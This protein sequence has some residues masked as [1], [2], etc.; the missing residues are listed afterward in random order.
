[1]VGSHG[2]TVVRLLRPGLHSGTVPK[3][4]ARLRHAWGPAAHKQ[5][6]ALHHVEASLRHFVE[7]DLLA[8]LAGSKRWGGMALEAAIHLGT[9]RIRCELR[10][11]SLE[12]DKVCLDFEEHADRLLARLPPERGWLPRLSPVQ[13]AAFYDALVGFCKLA[14]AELKSAEMPIAWSDWVLTWE[15]DQESDKQAALSPGRDER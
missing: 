1:V 6:E 15:R 13:S 7:R 8:V 10:W 2:E 4:Y 5:H 14:G 9:N 11:A 3:L 12:G